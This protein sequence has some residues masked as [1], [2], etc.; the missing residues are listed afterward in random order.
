MSLNKYYLS[1]KKNIINKLDKNLVILSEMSNYKDFKS[2]NS[3]KNALNQ[4]RK[5]R[6][7]QIFE[8]GLMTLKGNK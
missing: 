3:F 7:E 4:L 1:R 8:L 6:D 2:T 5:T